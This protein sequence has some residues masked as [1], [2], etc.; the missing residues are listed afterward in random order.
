[1]I[2]VSDTTRPRRPGEV[3][4]VDYNFIDKSVFEASVSAGGYLEYA[5]VFG[6]YYGT[7]REATEALIQAGKD[8]ILEIDW[9]GARQ[10]LD[11]VPVNL[12]VFIL[13]PSLQVL[14]QRLRGRGQDSAEV[15]ARRMRDAQ[16]QMEHFAEYDYL[17]VNDDFD[18]ALGELAA[19]VCASHLRTDVQRNRQQVLLRELL[20]HKQA[21]P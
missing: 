10:V 11:R 4:G 12:S 6:N 8:L 9:Q 14:E 7:S 18:V 20:A 15:I 5:Q 19:I 13:P 3:E 2:S 21:S 1:M 16:E 17:V